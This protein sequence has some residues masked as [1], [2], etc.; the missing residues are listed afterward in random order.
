MHPIVILAFLLLN[1]CGNNLEK[2]KR[3]SQKRQEELQGMF[4][5]GSSPSKK[6][7]KGSKKDSGSNRRG[8]GL[9]WGNGNDSDDDD[10]SDDDGFDGPDSPKN[11]EIRRLKAKLE[12]QK[13]ELKALRKEIKHIKRQGESTE[14]AEA[15]ARELEALKEH[16]RATRSL[17]VERLDSSRRDDTARRG[18]LLARLDSSRRPSSARAATPST[19]WPAGRH[20][21]EAGSTPRWG[22]S[23]THELG[24]SF[25]S[26]PALH[27]ASAIPT[28]AKHPG[29]PRG[30]VR[31]T[32]VLHR[33]RTL[34]ARVRDAVDDG[35][36]TDRSARSATAGAR[37][38][39]ESL[40]RVVPPPDHLRATAS[41]ALGDDGTR[42]T[43]LL[44]TRIGGA[45][46]STHG[47]RGAISPPT[48]EDDT[49]PRERRK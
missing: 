23:R 36:K 43:R 45:A 33:S 25:G 35:R 38:R 49:S 10:S 18:A 47:G 40:S 16:H 48:S 9:D 24:L 13:A 44:S 41:K 34:S 17:L 5:R 3:R 12:E 8:G 32:E 4:N 14:R 20:Y 42:T 19:S 27:S 15:V 28:P 29:S 31:T 11:D 6:G 26:T 37:S 21:S 46:A 7:K 39:R 2:P 30:G 22:A 1:F